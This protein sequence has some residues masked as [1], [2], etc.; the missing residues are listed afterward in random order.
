MSINQ[1]R[2]AEKGNGKNFMV[3]MHLNS[4]VIKDKFSDNIH[5][6]ISFPF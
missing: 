3:F 1:D 4:F 2:A 5:I 6:N